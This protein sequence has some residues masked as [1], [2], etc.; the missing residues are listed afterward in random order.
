[1]KDHL[2]QLLQLQTMDNKVKELEA[3]MKTLP[4]RLEPAR[5]DLTKLEAMLAGERQRL[6]ETETWKR[7]QEAALE[8]EQDG[9]RSAKQKLQASKTG[10]EY[11]AASREVDN[12]RKAISDR[13]AELKKLNETLGPTQ[14]QVATRDRDIEEIRRTLAVEEASIAERVAALQAE[15]AVASSGRAELR[16]TI[17]PSWL[18]IYE[19]LAAKKGYAVAPVVKGTCQG[20]HMSLPPQLNNTLAR[21]ESLEVCPRCGRIVYRKELLEPA[22]PEGSEGGEPPAA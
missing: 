12:K 14:V 7:Q 2:L 10:K 13:E 3:S 5:R 1:L 21:M 15:I 6:A 4:A 22:V 11:N 8:R 16:A 17:E 18:K 9:L 20:C 19:S